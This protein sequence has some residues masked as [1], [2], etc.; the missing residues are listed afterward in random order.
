MKFPGPPTVP[1]VGWDQGQAGFSDRYRTGV[2]V[3]G[4]RAKAS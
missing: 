1:V 3:R 2:A 4:A